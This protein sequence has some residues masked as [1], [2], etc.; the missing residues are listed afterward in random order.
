MNESLSHPRVVQ[1]ENVTKL[2]KAD[3]QNTAAVHSV[4]LEVRLGE[5]VVFLGPSGSGKTTLLTLISGLLQPTTGK[6]FLFGG[7]V[8][9][10]SNEELQRVRARRLGFVF[11]TFHLI[12]ALTVFENVLLVLRFTGLAKVTARRRVKDLLYQLDIPEL[13]EK[14]PYHLS[15]GQKQRVAVARAMANEADLIL[16]DEPTSSLESSQGFEIIR[17][18]HSYAREKNKCVIVASHDLR[19]VEFADRIVRL[20]DGVI[21]ETTEQRLL[22]IGP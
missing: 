8:C 7:D 1:L 20:Q 19:L 14:F 12:D 22:G 5:L 6:V 13:A 9:Q 4:T 3:G 2:F 21:R 18:L 11:Q 16:A 17:L 15:Q 10:Y